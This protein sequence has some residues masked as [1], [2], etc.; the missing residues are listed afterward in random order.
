MYFGFN[1]FVCP[2]M[3]IF[4]NTREFLCVSFHLFY[5]FSIYK[6]R[7]VCEGFCICA[8]RFI[9]VWMDSLPVNLSE[10][11]RF[12][13]LNKRAEH[14]REKEKSKIGQRICV[15]HSVCVRYICVCLYDGF[16]VFIFN[17][18]L[19]CLCMDKWL[20]VL[21]CMCV[22][23]CSYVSWFICFCVCLYTCIYIYMFIYIYT[24]T[25]TCSCVC[26]I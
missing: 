26:V 3:C 4:I 25:Y 13:S 9:I 20:F 6:Y 14:T 12:F 2:C 8:H 10:Q 15:Q 22:Y 18:V 5:F 7:L 21:V 16:C 19:T 17:C 24:Y 23:I 11:S 1:M